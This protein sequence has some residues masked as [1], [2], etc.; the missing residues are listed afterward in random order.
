M[1]ERYQTQ[2]L[3]N[4]LELKRHWSFYVVF[5]G[6]A[7]AVLVAIGLLI[8]GS[9]LFGL[10][11]L[12]LCGP[13]LAYYSNAYIKA[14]NAELLLITPNG[15]YLPLYQTEF[16]WQD[17]GPA[18]LVLNGEDLVLPLKN[19]SLYSIKFSAMERAMLGITNLGLPSNAK[20]S[21]WGNTAF[22]AQQTG[23]PQAAVEAQ[24]QAL[25][26]DALKSDD[27][28]YLS[29]PQVIR[30]GKTDAILTIINC[31]LIKRQAHAIESLPAVA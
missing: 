23:C 10:L 9:A 29:I 1:L 19:K 25:R 15:I 4:N 27:V 16:L 20:I 21:S 28:S 18:T 24:L 7:V 14:K 13:V 2:G 3:E 5:A 26:Q 12:S 11:V 6:S 17:L 8:F 31:E 22:I 30:A